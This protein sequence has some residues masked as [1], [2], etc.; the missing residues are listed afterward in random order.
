MAVEHGAIDVQSDKSNRH[1][2]SLP[3]VASEE[4]GEWQARQNAVCSRKA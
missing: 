1:A 3:E 4:S 2:S